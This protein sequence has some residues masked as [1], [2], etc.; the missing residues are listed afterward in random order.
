MNKK[1]IRELYAKG[2]YGKITQLMEL[3]ANLWSIKDFLY[4]QGYRFS[5][6]PVMVYILE[7][8]KHKNIFNEKLYARVNNHG[9]SFIQL[10]ELKFIIQNLHS[11][12]SVRHMLT[13][14]LCACTKYDLL[15]YLLSNTLIK[16]YNLTIH[17]TRHYGIHA[18]GR[19]GVIHIVKYATSHDII[20]YHPKTIIKSPMDKLLFNEQYDTINYYMKELYRFPY[21]VNDNIKAQ[22]TK[23]KKINYISDNVTLELAFIN[24]DVQYIK[25][26]NLTYINRLNMRTILKCGSINILKYITSN[27]Y[28]GRMSRLYGIKLSKCSHIEIFKYLLSDNIYKNYPQLFD[29]VVRKDEYNNVNDIEILKFL[30]SQT[31]MRKYPF[32]DIY[33]KNNLMYR[34]RPIYKILET[35]SIDT[36]KY[37]TNTTIENIYNGSMYYHDNTLKHLVSYKSNAQHKQK[38][39][40]YHVSD[41]ILTSIQKIPQTLRILTSDDMTTKYPVLHIDNHSDRTR[42]KIK[43]IMEDII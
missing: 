26:N 22:F 25:D 17:Q 32:I 12:S 4:I 2:R 5:H 10:H 39:R 7:H 3:N 41:L 13:K 35:G 20:S 14:K 21:L 27:D 28:N 18:C 40:D 11:Y 6:S 42:N 33:Y 34:C 38:R 37:V 15:K 24:D 29:D 23:N 31:I 16:K 8:F 30:S 43:D 1:Y 36:I 9:V 19:D